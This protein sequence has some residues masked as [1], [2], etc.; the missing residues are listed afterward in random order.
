M[1]WFDASGR[2]I[3]EHRSAFGWGQSR[4]HYEQ[5]TAYLEESERNPV[6]EG[7]TPPFYKADR[8]AEYRRAHAVLSRRLQ[9]AIDA[10]WEP[11]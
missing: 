9:D 1:T 4:E 10:G 8:E 2:K 3:A 5:M 7:Y 11:S 6:P